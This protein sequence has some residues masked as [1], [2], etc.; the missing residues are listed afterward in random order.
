LA[1]LT[2]TEQAETATV[3]VTITT[4][5][6]LSSVQEVAMSDLDRNQAIQHLMVFARDAL[7]R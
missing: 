6:G 7:M 2:F 4:E 3:L 1:H 5:C